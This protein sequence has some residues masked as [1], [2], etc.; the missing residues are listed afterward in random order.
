M[1]KFIQLSY[2]ELQDIY[3]R[4]KWVLNWL[5][6]DKN[7]IEGCEKIL[8]NDNEL[9]GLIYYDLENIPKIAKFEIC[10]NKKRKGFGKKVIKEFLRIH[11]LQFEIIPISDEVTIFWKKCGFIGNH[12]G[13]TYKAR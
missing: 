13:M 11:P 2:E 12:F 7:F 9:L 6:I 10:E 5:I 8:T 1:F 4:Q 3:Y